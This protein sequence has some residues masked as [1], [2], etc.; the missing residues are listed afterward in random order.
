MI[1]GILLRGPIGDYALVRIIS[2]NHK[3]FSVA[4]LGDGGHRNAQAD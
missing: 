1:I 4:L 3:P 2:R